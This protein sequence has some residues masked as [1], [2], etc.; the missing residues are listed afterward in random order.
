MVNNRNAFGLKNISGMNF[1]LWDDE[2]DEPHE[3]WDSLY[4]WYQISQR[5][6]DG[7]VLPEGVRIRKVTDLRL[8]W[9]VIINYYIE[10][11]NLLKNAP[12][13]GEIK[14]GSNKKIF[15][16]YVS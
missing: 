15:R 1:I 10:F 8:T 4:L 9:Q 13:T 2:I 11:K 16:R 7:Y 12:L 6:K 3:D 14:N 5:L